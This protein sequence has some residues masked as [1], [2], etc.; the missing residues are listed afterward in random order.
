MRLQQ[1]WIVNIDLL[2][3]QPTNSHAILRLKLSHP[4]RSRG[5]LGTS[6]RLTVWKLSG[7]SRYPGALLPVLENFYRA[8]CSPRLT[9]CP[10]VS[11]DAQNGMWTRNV[12]VPWSKTPINVWLFH[13]IIGDLRKRP[14]EILTL[15]SWRNLF[16]MIEPKLKCW[17]EEWLIEWKGHN[18]D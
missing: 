7:E 2:W 3:W 12:L 4:R 5:S 1:V 15:F 14:Q 17:S 18:S 11:D 8:Y 10:W 13:K 6:I 9:D 16:T